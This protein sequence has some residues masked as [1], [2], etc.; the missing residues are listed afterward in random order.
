[1]K[2]RWPQQSENN[3]LALATYFPLKDG[4]KIITWK[5][6]EN[7][8]SEMCGLSGWHFWSWL[9]ILSSL[10]GSYS[11]LR[12]LE[13]SPCGRSIPPCSIWLSLARAMEAAVPKNTPVNRPLRAVVLNGLSAFLSALDRFFR[14]GLRIRTQVKW[15]EI[16]LQWI[17]M[18]GK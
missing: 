8:N 18:S 1:M 13:V 12:W 3:M 7:F 14:L 2:Y 17:D 5:F 16:K 15:T 11:I 6:L 10:G 9:F 4:G